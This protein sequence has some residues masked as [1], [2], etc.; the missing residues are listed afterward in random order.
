MIV[1]A[2]DKTRERGVCHW[3]EDEAVDSE[4]RHTTPRV[5]VDNSSDG[6][7]IIEALTKHIPESMMIFMAQW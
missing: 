3:R 4:R 1:F 2:L 7:C 5:S 6:E